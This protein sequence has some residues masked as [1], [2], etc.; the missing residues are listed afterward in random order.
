MTGFLGAGKTSL[1]AHLLDST[2]GRRIGVLV[3]DLAR[4]SVD[5][6][7]LNGGEHI[8]TRDS[9][10][11]RAIPGGR[12][13]AG[14]RDALIDEIVSLLDLDDPV[15]AIV[16]ETSG[17]S[18]VL[19]LQDAL[20][21]DPALA[22]RATLDTVITLVDT[23]TYAGFRRDPQLQPLLADQLVAADLIVLNKYDRTGYW[24]RRGTR[25]S[26][27]KINGN[28]VIGTAEFGRLPADEII[29]TGRRSAFFE[30]SGLASTA[31]TL[32]ERAANPNFR[33]LLAR[34]LDDPRPFHP[35]RLDQWL[36]GEWPGIIRIKGFAWLATDM[37]HVYVVDVAGSQREIGME[38]TWYAALPEDERPQDREIVDAIRNGPYGDRRQKITVIGV[39]DA[40][41]RE[42]RNLRACMLS[43]P[44]LDRGPREWRNLPDPVRPRFNM[45]E[46]TDESDALLDTDT[47]ANALLQTDAADTT[48]GDDPSPPTDA[49]TADE[50][51]RTR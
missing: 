25:K 28:A 16:V 20:S 34:V 35:E 26:V 9:E 30:R 22:G 10:L 7:F 37:D 4:E 5:T 44:E 41:E 17:S 3:N 42:L 19:E 29:G 33:P 32:L 51:S 21:R 14:R 12:V 48:A 47:T 13:G 24:R 45:V 8:E 1:I 49:A 2:A 46:P 36:N 50:P 18:P 43:G 40:V 15:E 38:G 39:P 31:R 23:S 11:L 27:A 6:A